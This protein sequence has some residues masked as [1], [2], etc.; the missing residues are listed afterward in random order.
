MA[1]ELG[2]AG[3]A[4]FLAINPNPDREVKAAWDEKRYRGGRPPAAPGAK[5]ASNVGRL[6]NQQSTSSLRNVKG[7]E[8]RNSLG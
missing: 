1:E 6:N 5:N 8:S 2:L 7:T 3:A 4:D